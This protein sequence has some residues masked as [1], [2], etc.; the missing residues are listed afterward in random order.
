MF[1]NLEA[2]SIKQKVGALK[3]RLVL[4]NHESI[5][6]FVRKEKVFKMGT[7]IK[8]QSRPRD[9]THVSALQADTLT[10][11]PPGKQ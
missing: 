7:A 3:Q 11:E 9:R 10:S 2:I 5:R 8:I 1:R 4:V 6:F